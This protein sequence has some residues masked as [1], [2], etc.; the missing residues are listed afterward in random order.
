MK[1][2]TFTIDGNS[3]STDFSTDFNTEEEREEIIEE[4]E[5]SALKRF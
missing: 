5:R 4:R 3:F 1:R 2:I